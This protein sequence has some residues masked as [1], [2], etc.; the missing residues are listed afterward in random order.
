MS[1]SLVTQNVLIQLHR[2]HVTVNLLNRIFLLTLW[3]SMLMR[4]AFHLAMMLMGYQKGSWK[5]I[6]FSFKKLP[7]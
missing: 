6:M 7:V 5:E 4:Q 1:Q 3:S 2:G